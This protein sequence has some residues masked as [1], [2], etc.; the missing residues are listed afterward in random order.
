[1]REGMVVLGIHK[2]VPVLH[3]GGIYLFSN[4]SGKMDVLGKKILVIMLRGGDI[5]LFY[6][7][8]DKMVVL[9]G[10][11]K[12]VLKPKLLDLVDKS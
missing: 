1:M 5:F 12:N 11:C 6:C 10:Q 7:G 9:D 3:E 8:L 4:G 2:F